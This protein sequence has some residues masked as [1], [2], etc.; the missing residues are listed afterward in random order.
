MNGMGQGGRMSKGDRTSP[1]AMPA[2]RKP[3][4]MTSPGQGGGMSP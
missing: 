1:K 4:A 3:G 2:Q